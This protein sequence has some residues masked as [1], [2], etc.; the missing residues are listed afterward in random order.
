MIVV[1]Q[2]AASKKPGAGHL[3]RR[4]GRRVLFVADPD[5]APEV[6]GCFY[7]RPDDMADTGHSWR[8]QL[9]RY[10]DT[11]G[12]NSLGLL[13]AWQLYRNPTYEV[14]A[15]C[16]GLDRLYILSA[17]WGLLAAEFLTPN[18]D[19][20]FSAQA[21][22]Y[23]R[24]RKGDRYDDISMLPE[25]T[26]EPVVLLVSKDY[27]RLA[28]DLTERIRSQKYLFFNSATIPDAP[29]CNL[30]R[31]KTTTRTNWQYE[32]AYALIEGRVGV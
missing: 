4:D 22:R 12:D 18:Y 17:G 27:V 19:I 10:N 32:C 6:S 20:T 29:G 15:E 1:I 7:A 28:C 30:K 23:K 5:G 3:R 9:R 2:C 11:T 8:H 26:D 13:P 31:Y 21:D 24:R 16:Y 25:D 14:L